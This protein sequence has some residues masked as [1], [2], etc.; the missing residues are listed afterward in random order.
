MTDTIYWAVKLDQVS[1]AK[2]LAKVRPRHPK[3][4][5][6]HVTLVFNPSDQQDKELAQ[7]CGETVVLVVNKHVYDNRGQAVQ[8]DGISRYDGGVPH[9]TISC[10]PDTKPVYSNRLLSS[11]SSTVEDIEAFSV[12]GVI[13]R[14]TRLRTWDTECKTLKEEPDEAPG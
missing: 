2:L 12:T 5:A 1:V 6:E 14:F 10:M 8:V 11:D 7:L 4:F 9:V 13:A 3:V